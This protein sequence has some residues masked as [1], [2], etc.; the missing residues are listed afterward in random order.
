M[1]EAV[2]FDLDETLAVPDR[3]R[4][5]ILEDVTA[6]TGIPSISRESYLDA[7]RQN[8]TQTTRK[9]IFAELLADRET[10]ADAE[11]LAVAYRQTIADSLSPVAGVES[12]LAD[13]RDRYSVGLLTNG[14]VR[15]QRDKLETL[16]W[17]RAFDAALVTG[18]LEA[19]KPDPRAFDAILSEL[20]VD[21]E[22]AVY[23]GD[24]VEADIA[25]ATNAGMDAIQVLKPDGPAPD[26]RAAG[27]LAQD[28]I[29]TELPDVL[30]TL[31]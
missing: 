15:A 8:L 21:A 2:V 16:G 11:E 9:P 13:L 24:D 4:E 14:P 27:H 10:D 25:G 28:S 5:T 19:G 6:A 30:A 31:E 17:E 18:E 7:H 22:N 26:D 20:A 3:D 1:V 23:V 12:L 29:A